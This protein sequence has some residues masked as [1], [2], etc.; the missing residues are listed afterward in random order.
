MCHYDVLAYL[1]RLSLNGVQWALAKF[2]ILNESDRVFYLVWTLYV[3]DSSR[4]I[5]THF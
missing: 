3:L 2:V 4:P 5:Q 1:A